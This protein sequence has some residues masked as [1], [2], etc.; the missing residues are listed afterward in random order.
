MHRARVVLEFGVMPLVSPA[1]RI[2]SGVTPFP[3]KYNGVCL[4]WPPAG[5]ESMTPDQKLQSWEFASI[6]LETG[7]VVSAMSLSS[8]R[9]FLLTRYNFL[10]L[11]GSGKSA[12]K[13]EDETCRKMRYFNYKK[14]CSVAASRSLNSE[15]EDFLVMME[16]AFQK[17]LRIL[18]ILL[19]F[20]NLKILPLGFHRYMYK[21]QENFHFFSGVWCNICRR[22]KVSHMML[23][24]NCNKSTYSSS[25]NL[26]TLWGNKRNSD[27]EECLIERR[28]SVKIK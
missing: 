5:W 13:P 21:I 23:L 15:D 19:I 2:W 22:A 6:L 26:I 7:G 12:M 14:L 28:V 9:S 27:L 25:T 4:T 20:W 1:R 18:T 8:S 24:N 17:K 10:C 3:I 11:P 16:A